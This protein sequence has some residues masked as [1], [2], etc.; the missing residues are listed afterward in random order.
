MPLLQYCI[1]TIFCSLWAA[2]ALG[3][4]ITSNIQSVT[5]PGGTLASPLYIIDSDAS[6]LSA[7]YERDA[8]AVSVPV[9]FSK[10]SA[11]FSNTETFRVSVQL[12]DSN[13]N[14]VTLQGGATSVLS[15]EQEISVSSL[16][17]NASHTFAVAV[18]P[19]VDLGAG[20]SYYVKATVQRRQIAFSGGFFTFLWPTSDGPD[21]SSSF[22]VV[23]FTN[24]TSGDA[25]FNVRGYPTATPSWTRSHAVIPDVGF[26]NTFRVNVPYFFARYDLGGATASI[27]MR[28]T[29]TLTDDLNTVI[30]L[31]DGGVSSSLLS[32]ANM[33]TGSGLPDR[34]RTYSG[35]LPCSFEPV[36]QLDSAG[37]TYRVRVLVEHIEIP[38]ASYRNDGTSGNTALTRLLHFNGNLA[39]GSLNTNF[40][41]LANTPSPGLVSAGQIATTIT[42]GNNAGTIPGFAS[43]RFGNNSIDTLSVQLLSNGN[44]VVTAGAQP[45][46]VSGGAGQVTASYG[47]VAV[48]YPSVT[49]QSVG[50][51]AS[52]V[53]VQLPQGLGF[54]PDRAVQAM[55]Y[56]SVF[57][58]A[59][60][61][62][63][64]QSF[65][66]TGT[67]STAIAGQAWVFDES[68]SLLYRVNSCE[69]TSTGVI[70]FQ[71]DTNEW[72][73]SGAMT[74]LET[75]QGLGQHEEAS[76]SRR[77]NNEGYLRYVETA[78]PQQLEFKAALDGTVRTTRAEMQTRAGEY[79]THMPHETKIEWLSFG[80][81]KITNGNVSGH[82]QDVN[83][84]V[85]RYD[86]ACTNATCG[87]VGGVTRSLQ[88]STLV[89]N[90][91]TFSPD[92]GLHGA[93]EISPA[94]LEWGFKGDSMGGAGDPT[95]RTDLFIDFTFFAPGNQMYDEVN[96]LGGAASTK[97]AR[98]A[99][100]I[101][102]AGYLAGGGLVYPEKTPYVNGVGSYA[103]MNFVQA[104]GSPDTGGSAIADMPAMSLY[105][106][107]ENVSKYYVRQSGISG[108]Q[109]AEAESFD[110]NAILYNYAF[111]FSRFQLT[112]LSDENEDSWI[113]GAVNVPYPSDFSQKF[114]ELRLGCTGALE[115]ATIDPSDVG[116]KDLRY[117]RGKFTP[118]TMQFAEKSEASCNEPRCLTIG[119]TT[120]A[121]NVPTP[122]SGVLGF[123]P[124]G[125]IAAMSE[126]FEGTDGRL[127]LPA[128][129]YMNGPGDERYH[130]VPVSK[131]YF[132]SY[133]ATGRP[134]DGYVGFGAT[135]N[136]PFFEDLKL[137]IM[138]SARTS[139]VANI[140]LTGGWTDGGNTFFSNRNFDA[141]HRAF[142]PL[143]TGISVG[144]YQSPTTENAYV[145]RAVQSIFG[146][147][148]LN[149]PMKWD[150]SGRFFETWGGDRE[151]DLFVV[152]VQHQ[153]EYLSAENAEITFGVQYDGIPQ[154]NLASA[155]FDAAEEQVGAVKAIVDG[156]SEEITSTL[157]RGVDEL[158]NLVTD[159]IELLLDD[160]LKGIER[161]VIEPLYD[162]FATLIASAGLATVNYNDFVDTN[163]GQLR[164]L[165][166]SK[167]NTA[168][169]G[170]ATLQNRINELANTV[171]SAASVITRVDRALEDGILAIDSVVGEIS[172]RR[173]EAGQLVAIAANLNFNSN[174]RLGILARDSNGERDIVERLLEKLLRELAPQ[175][176]GS[177]LFGGL[178]Q[179]LS[180]EIN[181]KLGGLLDEA[182]PALDRIVEVLEEARSFLTEVRTELSGTGDMIAEF[183]A[184]L[185]GATSEIND[186]IGNVRT[187]TFSFFDQI[188]SAARINNQPLSTA[189]ILL[190]EFSKEEFVA[191]IKS[192]IRDQLLQS[193]FVQ[194]I[195]ATLR[196]Y[197]S[198]LEIAMN[199]AIDSMFS[200]VTNLCKEVIDEFLGPIDDAINGLA[201]DVNQYVGAGSLDG[202][203]H[204]EGDT[205]R[206][207]R[208]DAEVSLK[209]PDEMALKGFFEYNCYDS[210]TEGAACVAPG[211]STVEVKIGAIDAPLDWV[212]PG[213][214]ADLT[215]WFTM[216]L[217]IDPEDDE[218]AIYPKGIGGSLV[219]T[220]GEIN[221]ESLKIIKFGAAVAVGIDDCYLAAT[222]TVVISNYEATG[223]IFFGKSCSIEPLEMVD[224]DV[225]GVLGPAPFIGAYVYGEVWIPISEVVLGIPAS[226]LFQISAGVGAGAFFFISGPNNT[227]TFGGKM[228][229]G[230]S[231]EA[232]CVVSIRGEVKMVGVMSGSSLRFSGTGTLRGKAGPCPF[233]VKFKESVKVTY[234]DGNFKLD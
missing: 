136:V 137:H 212:N 56:E 114:Q 38:A 202:Y 181:A 14:V 29:V 102:L 206:R 200:Q 95:H 5:T 106:L 171:G 46:I 74:Q 57:S 15:A 195:Q 24:T 80:T 147:V 156:A 99:S 154:I 28:L 155:V 40:E 233:C 132:N 144:N 87:P 140:Y 70:A 208:I 105:T 190:D 41:W 83:A 112:F 217:R 153:V 180:A 113:N 216:A 34:P 9:N 52:G 187:K 25:A 164:T 204:I 123:L 139:S 173:N 60:A 8:F 143:S 3:Q 232:L 192:E 179:G 221:F 119:L 61:R 138:T 100:C 172:Q 81:Y 35:N 220:E 151:V 183:Q 65:R 71:S 77:L 165:L 27:G 62:T 175:G 129:I 203:A 168:G 21:S 7:G 184:I 104:S 107:Q 228:L 22:T 79:Y 193:L 2:T 222:A 10:N 189:R 134:D 210:T 169:A 176:L 127:G 11:D 128:S 96:P 78:T 122:L 120:G 209:V 177:E 131:L 196:G 48:K 226:C 185:A 148:D 49:L 142:P 167:F 160:A 182:D 126:N 133:F 91:L 32:M 199:S 215:V 26:D 76:M 47:G 170:V 158:G 92:G 198:D 103:G 43:F 166:D 17:P 111:Q 72:V 231:G 31:K 125:D 6:N 75:Q 230:V 229:L 121:A 23:H 130:L 117:W 69:F 59:G 20:G 201:G 33:L 141:G 225:A 84:L 191:Y 18:D 12:F 145:P 152:N 219:M 174:T 224:P 66:H 94:V 1:R 157:Y 135:C 116:E 4:T 207:L 186:I 150:V 188:A 67:L 88:S 58:F 63:L 218:S 146:L 64:N 223:G 161:D 98:G 213:V 163:T 19:G 234:Q 97:S 45:L 124:S 42:V 39:F 227:P 51:V 93:G 73:H 50:P 101:S 197:I 118:H 53:E 86:A 115:S 68:R 89:S 54:N 30:P 37:R 16:F 13:D 55:R 82:L 205:L 36:A 149:Y 85:V 110:P 108:R 159:N 194:Q 162:D 211:T 44:C 178:A 109:V 214:K 90:Q